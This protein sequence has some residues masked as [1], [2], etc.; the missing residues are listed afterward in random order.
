MVVG[1]GREQYCPKDH[2]L[3]K[4]K[5]NKNHKASIDCASPV[6]GAVGRKK[7]EETGKK[8]IGGILNSPFFVSSWSMDD[9][10]LICLQG[11]TMY[12]PSSFCRLIL[13]HRLLPEEQ[14]ILIS[15]PVLPGSLFRPPSASFFSS[16]SPVPRCL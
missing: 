5:A 9:N 8:S 3:P 4:H 10:T 11:S 15:F 16:R 1:L 7:V 13:N 6:Q 2:W 14:K 12:F